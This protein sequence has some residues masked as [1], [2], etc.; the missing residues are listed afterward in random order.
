MRR[1]VRQPPG[2]RR[3]GLRWAPWRRV[4][5]RLH[6]FSQTG[7]RLA[8]VPLVVLAMGL[9][10]PTLA[11]GSQAPVPSFGRAGALPALPSGAVSEGLMPASQRLT[12]TVALEP[13]DPATLAAYIAALSNRSSPL[14][15]HFLTPSGFARRF[16]PSAA[17]IQ[18]VQGWLKG[19]GTVTAPIPVDHLSVSASGTVAQLESAFGVVLKRYRTSGGR[20]AWRAE[21]T[22]RTAP[23]GAVPGI[24]GLDTV[25]VPHPLLAGSG[26][27]VTAAGTVPP[28]SGG[29][30]PQPCSAASAQ[31]NPAYTADEI[32]SHYGMWPLYTLGDFGAG[33]HVAL[34]ELE[35]NLP[36]DISAYESCYGIS[37]T[38]NYIKVDGFNQV[39]AGSGE[40]TADIEDVMGL[41]PQAVI[42]VY[43]A[44]P[45]DAYYNYQAIVNADQDQ[46]I[47]TSWGACEKA[48]GSTEAQAEQALFAQA[49]TQGQTVVAA[50]GDSGSTGCY[51]QLGSPYSSQLW[52]DDPASQPYVVGVGGT[53]LASTGAETVWNDSSITA[54]AGGGGLSALWCM[55]S[56]QYASA[57]PGLIN[58]YSQTNSACPSSSPYVRQVPDVSADADPQTG[59][60]FYYQSSWGV[61]GGTSLA[62][63]TWAATA[64]ITDGS[65]FCSAFGSGTPGALPQ[66]LYAIAASSYYGNAFNDVTSGN[67]AYTP[68]GYAGTLYPATAGY[69]LA[70]GLGTPQLVDYSASG[71]PSYFNPGLA[72]LQCYA[73]RPTSYSDTITSV[74]PNSALYSAGATVTIQGTGFVPV[75][76]ADIVLDGSTQVVADCTSTTTCT[77]ALPPSPAGTVDLRMEVEDLAE[78][79]VTTADKFTWTSPVPGAP[80]GLAATP[81]SGQAQLSWSPPSY[82]GTSAIS[83]YTVTGTDLTTAQSLAPTTV[84]G[85]PVP[86][87]ATIT[88]LADGD[89]YSFQVAATN[90]SGTGPASSPAQLQAPA[91][92]APLTPARICDT[93]S[94]SITGQPADQCTGQT[95]VPGGSISVQVTG[96]GGVPASATAVVANVTATDTTAASYLTVWPAGSNRPL[97]SNLNW[98]AGQTVANLVTV[99][100]SATGALQI[101]NANGK[102]DVVVDVEGFYGPMPA[103]SAGLGFSPLSP[104]RI[105]DTRPTS[106]T[107]QPSD[108]CTGGTL[109][110]GGSIQVQVTGHGGV[111]T[112]ATAV[113]ANVTV[114]DTTSASYLTAWPAGQ[115]RPVASTLNWSGGETRANRVVI[116]LSA[117]GA[118]EFYNDLG[119]ADLVVDVNGYYS[120]GSPGLFE[121]VSP[122][123]I[124]DTRPS[125]ITGQ[126]A[127]Q[128]TGQTLGPSGNLPVQVTGL[129]GVPA[130]AAA[131]VAN[132][133]ATDTTASSYLTVY[134]QSPMPLA[135][136]LNW[137]SGYTVPN[138]VVCELSPGGGV[139][140]FNDLGQ[141]DVVVDVF[142]WFT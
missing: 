66:G 81:G 55:P 142:G 107:G 100:L 27:S 122:F 96:Y 64:A 110:P 86:T 90:G 114:T 53:S 29:P 119:Q 68:S 1:L 42:D 76:G 132:V 47:S 73:Y 60:V 80:T 45:A 121:A 130:G 18:R 106:I 50:A 7:G 36:S 101:Y 3:R 16:G 15:R 77:A 109:G 39:G 140:V 120:S 117:T 75:A 52:A 67:N 128:C 104:A 79:P 35:P 138:L 87:S 115:S 11:A 102:T 133:T 8:L 20:I 139:Q 92:F 118:L 129:A 56:Y 125:S 94:T 31:A 17:T 99:P 14:F 71:S 34:F 9:A 131:V 111:P 22:P 12:V 72:A 82:S 21:G 88:G 126:P 59:Y 124:C 93:R 74:T 23:A 136:D 113:V 19:F 51:P 13:R 57:I 58:S 98:S 70:S 38:V 41:A 2:A 54:G 30:G 49:A 37:T 84:S 85:S 89:S 4:G 26:A 78:S 135:S 10:T 123:R 103:G 62:A 112:S 141:V 83:S 32:S 95:L 127:D 69:D 5:G 108:Q 61:V 28:T 97:A 24:L 44:P 46:V 134:P 65:P 40:A 33:V 91:Q 43:Q 63:P 137:G 48:V 6:R 116:P 105:C 25:N